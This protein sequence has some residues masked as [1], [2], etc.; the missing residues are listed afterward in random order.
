MSTLK[1]QL[2]K[3]VNNLKERRVEQLKKIEEKIQEREKRLQ[4]GGT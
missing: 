2:R 4:Q 3:S 1:D